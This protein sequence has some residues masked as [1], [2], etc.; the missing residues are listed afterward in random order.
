M[1]EEGS[2]EYANNRILVAVQEGSRWFSA[3]GQCL[4]L[5]WCPASGAALK[6]APSLQLLIAQGYNLS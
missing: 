3:D 6:Q 1:K 5:C 4:Q 2:K